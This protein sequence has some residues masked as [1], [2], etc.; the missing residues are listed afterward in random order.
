MESTMSK[1]FKITT[2]FVTQVFDT[3]KQEFVEQSFH[4]GDQTDYEDFDGN[5]LSDKIQKMIDTHYLP[6]NMKQPK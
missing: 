4:A 6:F 2:G 3:E 5:P 1:I